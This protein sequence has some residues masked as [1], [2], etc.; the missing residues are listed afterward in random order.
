M[1]HQTSEIWQLNTYKL[2]RWRLKSMKM[3]NNSNGFIK[4]ILFQPVSPKIKAKNQTDQEKI[5]FAFGWFAKKIA[6]LV[7]SR[8]ASLTISV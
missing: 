2:A 6:D 1:R 3:L 5:I 4:V 7:R 8:V